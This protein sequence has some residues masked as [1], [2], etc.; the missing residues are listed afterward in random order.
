MSSTSRR[1]FLRS[2]SASLALFAVGASARAEETF[3]PSS[4]E[5]FDRIDRA[6]NH[7]NAQAD[8]TNEDGA[9]GWGEAGALAAYLLMYRAHRDT[10]YLGKLID[11]FDQVLKSRDSVRGVKDYRGLSLPAWQAAGHYTCGAATLN[12][13]RGNPVLT[14]RT[15]ARPVQKISVQ[16]LRGAREDTFTLRC[17]RA[18]S[19]GATAVED[20]YENLT[21]RESDEHFAPRYINA[22]FG[23]INRD[24]KHLMI[25]A[26]DARATKATDN[27]APGEPVAMKPLPYI[28]AVHT[29]MILQPVVEFVRLAPEQKKYRAKAVEYLDA[30]EKAVAIFDDEWREDA[31]TGEGWLVWRRGAPVAFDGSD[32]P[33]NQYLALGTVMIHL[34]VVASTPQLREKYGDRATKIARTLKND[35]KPTPAGGFS[36]TYFWSKGKAFNGWIAAD[37]VSDFQPTYVYGGRSDGHKSLEDSSHAHID[38][39]FARTAFENHLGGVFD[40]QDMRRF[41][42]TYTK[43]ILAGDRSSQAVDGSGK[44]GLYD[45]IVALGVQFARWDPS[46][47]DRVKRL[48]QSIPSD[49][50]PQ[51]R[52]LGTAYLNL[53]AKQKI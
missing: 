1:Q 2:A 39:T 5:E 52:L 27:P 9:L 15:A 7:G 37:N 26:A 16:V 24:G 42:A 41:A 43:Q 30:V 8:K 49:G 51:G 17:V 53:A 18:E 13:A 32:Q 46:L 36:W 48:Y 31:K 40:E 10:H 6:W 44:Q 23:E 50:A 34:S 19:T 35:L 28:Y 3:D 4:R 29:G 12:D 22:R 38:V 25:T 21:M 20:V 11:Q 45:N 14:V 47:L 33:H